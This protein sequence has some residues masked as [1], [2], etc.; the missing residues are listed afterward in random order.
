M[1]T[2]TAPII[3]SLELPNADGREVE[4]PK[5]ITD[6]GTAIIKRYVEFFFVHIRNRRTRRAYRNG[7]NPFLE[8]C[9][10]RGICLM[11]ITPIVIAAYIESHHGAAPTV[12]QHLAAIKQL[13]SWLQAGGL[14]ERNPAQ[15]VRGIKHRVKVGKTPVLSDD[16]VKKLLSDI[17][18]SHNVGLRDRALIATMFYSFARIG[19]VL[20]MQVGDY[21]TKGQSHWLRL[22]EKGGKYHEVPVHAIL[23]HYIDAYI[24]AGEL[25]DVADAPLFLTTRGRTRRLTERRL[26]QQ[27]AWAMVRRRAE[28]SGIT[29]NVC[30]HSFRA[31]G[32]TNFLSHGGSL[33]NAQR[34][35]G[36][37]VISTTAL[38]DRR[39]DA[40]S[41]DE[42]ERIRL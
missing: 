36:H 38:Y 6:S 9:E 23:K 13:F 35:A 17:D 12:N 31:S 32:I 15:E 3:G 41:L 40:I 8:W 7:I 21:F 16:E 14:I 10:A 37:E 20:A 19:A 33:D 22:H 18:I 1:T 5:L 2:F 30:N 39:G 4:L 24:E 34:I 42:I 28:A 27:E 26:Q 25:A 11:A 29:T